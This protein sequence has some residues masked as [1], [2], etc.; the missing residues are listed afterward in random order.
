MGVCPVRPPVWKAVFMVMGLRRGCSGVQ[1][2][3]NTVYTPYEG[4][5]L[6]IRLAG[7]L[8]YLTGSLRGDILYFF[9][10]LI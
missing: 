7:S 8:G 4:F 5:N 2:A 3:L 1:E 9:V 6:P 10:I